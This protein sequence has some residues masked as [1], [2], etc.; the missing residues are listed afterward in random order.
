MTCVVFTA[1][2]FAF[3]ALLSMMGAKDSSV[4][5]VD[6]LYILLLFAFVASLAA[7]VF[8]VNKLHTA[9]KVIVHYIICFLDMYLCVFVI[10]FKV[11]GM[12]QHVDGYT[13]SQIFVAS[14]MFTVFYAIV[15]AVCLIL[16]K[17]TKKKKNQTYTKQFNEL[18]Q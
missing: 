5:F 14:V 8:S 1:S 9:I 2:V 11:S 7:L 16:C 15:I 10:F 12:E 3:A 4:F 13:P 6:R 17:A 18:A